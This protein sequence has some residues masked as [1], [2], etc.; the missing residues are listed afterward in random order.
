MLSM[1]VHPQPADGGLRAR[2]KQQT[3]E[4]IWRAALELFDRQGFAATTIPEIAAMA[5]VSPR[6]VSSYFPSKEELAFPEAHETFDRLEARLAERP[7]GETTAE[8]L[9]AWI[10]DE[11]PRWDAM[12]D[13]AVV[14]RRVTAANPELE[15][16]RRR[17]M[18]RGEDLIAQ[19]IATDLD[20]S[21]DDL[22]ARMASAATLAIFHV[23]GAHKD[24]AAAGCTPAGDQARTD[25]SAMLDRALRFVSAGIRELQTSRAT[26]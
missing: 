19:S 25:A 2:K 21:P 23:L 5:N 26:S 18:A 14:Q 22:V 7:R 11:T 12:D 13:Q 6:T 15:V 16:Y 3:R 8:T 24:G 4:E 9:R 10:A 20:C 17:I 1:T